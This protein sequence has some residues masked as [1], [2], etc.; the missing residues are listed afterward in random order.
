MSARI[1]IDDD[2]LPSVRML[3]AKLTAEYY[4]V[5]TAIDG[6]SALEVVHEQNPDLILLDVMIRAWTALKHA[7]VSRPIV[8]ML[9]SPSSW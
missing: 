4:D 1:L 2:M 7:G 5:I 3:V 8:N 6:P 9:T